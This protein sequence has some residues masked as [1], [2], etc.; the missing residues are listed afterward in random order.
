MIMSL[1]GSLYV[2]KMDAHTMEKV[3]TITVIVK[4]PMFDSFCPYLMSYQQ[5]S[6][7]YVLE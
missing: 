3:C 1:S 2:M 4:I 6:A 5:V 7:C